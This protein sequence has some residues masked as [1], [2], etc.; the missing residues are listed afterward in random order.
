[1][2]AREGREGETM[3]GENSVKCKRNLG[4]CVSVWMCVC[5]WRG[6]S[7]DDMRSVCLTDVSR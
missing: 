5:V 7:V 3:N 6:R 4:E 2:R 1:M